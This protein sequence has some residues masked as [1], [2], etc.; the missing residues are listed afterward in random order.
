M[1]QFIVMILGFA[2]VVP[3]LNQR[4]THPIL[5][6]VGSVA[7]IVAFHLG[8]GALARLLP[9]RCRHCRGQARFR[10]FGWWPFTYRYDCRGCGQTMGFE[11]TGR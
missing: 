9:V 10:G 7:F 5:L 6:V 11:L 8:L 2:G 3:S 1:T 4:G